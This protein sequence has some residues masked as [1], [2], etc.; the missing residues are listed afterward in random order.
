[1]VTL[2][3]VISADGFIARPDGSEDFIPDEYWPYTLN[4]IKKYNRVLMG[5]KTYQTIQNYDE[6]LRTSFDDLP[7]QKIIV[8][9]NR[10]FHPKYSYEV[11]STPED[12]IDPN[13]NILVTS[14]PTL[15]NYLIQKHLVDKITYHKVPIFI[16]SGIKPYE[17]T[18]LIETIQIPIYETVR[19]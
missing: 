10:N 11:V 12:A 17:T 4:V 3:N 18:D 7:I 5:R 16:G 8:T 6:K 15:N 19:F 9:K 13:L 14:G 2:Y 1:M